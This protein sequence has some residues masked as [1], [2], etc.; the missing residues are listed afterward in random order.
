MDLDQ[1]I[2]DP[3]AWAQEPI[4]IAVIAGIILLVVLLVLYLVQRRRRR[5]SAAYKRQFGAEYERTAESTSRRKAEHDLEDRVER[6]GDVEL[7][8]LSASERDR[9]RARFESVQASFVDSPD[10]AV[11]A[12]DGLIDE[13]AVTRGY[14]DVG[15]R[16]RRLADVSVDYPEEVA[17]HRRGLAQLSGGDERATTEQQRKALLAARTLF[18]RL[19]GVSDSDA[20]PQPPAPLAAATREAEAEDNEQVVV[21]DM[22]GPQDTQAP[23]DR[24][25]PPASHNA[26]RDRE[27][28]RVK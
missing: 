26:N 3:V 19:V 12:A 10:S 8:W 25:A 11:L 18:D 22:D 28:P 16:S 9:F 5:R 20:A 2:D 21:V 24:D 1:L 14:P 7:R 23:G 6:H 27:R 4:G 13:V 15:E 17:A